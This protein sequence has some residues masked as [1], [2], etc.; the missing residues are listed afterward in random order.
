MILD[1]KEHQAFLLELFHQVQ[2]PGKTLDIA[3]EIKRAIMSAEI[4]PPTSTVP[5]DLTPPAAR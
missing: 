2:F 1:K 3:Y 4:K 5:S